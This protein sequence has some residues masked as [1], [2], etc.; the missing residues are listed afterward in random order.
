MKRI[1]NY[2][3]VVYKDYLAANGL[4]YKK[5]LMNGSK[6]STKKMKKQTKS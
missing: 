3:Y 6:L 5:I 2:S 1:Q 4:F